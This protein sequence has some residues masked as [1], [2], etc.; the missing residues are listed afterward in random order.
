M[1]RRKYLTAAVATAGAGV[2]FF[3]TGS[4]NR[5][6][7]FYVRQQH[8]TPWDQAAQ[9]SDADLQRVG[10]DAIGEL[11]IHTINV[12]Q[13]DSTLIITPENEHV[14][15]DTGHALDNGKFVLEYLEAHDITHL[16]FLVATHP[17]WD[18]I[19]GVP[20]VLETYQEELDGID[21][22]VQVNVPHTTGTYRSFVEARDSFDGDI[23][24]VH[25][26]D[27]MPWGD[28]LD[29]T[30]LNP[31]QT[32]EDR[33]PINDNSLA[34]HIQYGDTSMILPSD[35]EAPAEERM[36]EEHGETLNA[37]IY[38]VGHHGDRS[39]STDEFMNAVD[40]DVAI[41]SSAYDSR[42]GHPHDEFIKTASERNID[43]Y[44]TGTH[45]SIITLSDGESWNI[46][47]Q[48]GDTTDPAELQNQPKI[49]HHPTDGFIT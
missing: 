7:V 28:E 38:K 26:G 14:L 32:I 31:P 47:T 41:L 35:S 17:H 22:L 10:T 9:A 27:E 18:H 39:S 11:Q 8:D 16:D 44:W 19:G 36:V 12:A 29:I 6:K 48:G 42:W 45:G 4:Y 13:A 43:T 2:V 33:K 49:P 15:V 37:D 1:N 5:A 40:P 23:V 46:L 25:K 30:V 24:T 21:T 34:F 20:E 3:K